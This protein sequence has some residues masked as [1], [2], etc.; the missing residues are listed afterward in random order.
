LGFCDESQSKV[1]YHFQDERLLVKLF[2]DN[3]L[4]TCT[5]DSRF[6]PPSVE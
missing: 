1:C 6:C 3:A 4:K 2:D 5:A